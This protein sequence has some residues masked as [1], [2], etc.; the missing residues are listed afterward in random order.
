M[1][2]CASLIALWAGTVSA[3]ELSGR[4][5][6]GREEHEPGTERSLLREAGGPGL[7][8]PAALG[9]LFDS[10]RLRI[11]HEVSFALSTQGAETWSRGRYLSRIDFTLRENLLL[12]MDLGFESV[13]SSAWSSEGARFVLPN[14][15]LSY[16]PT[17]S[18]EIRLQYGYG[19]F[20]SPFWH[21]DPFRR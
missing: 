13:S 8:S 9:G 18:T 21:T 14:F 12:E 11:G 7:R 15:S 6:E 16:R 5:P 20:R 3:R 19:T 4:A 2:L 17:S 10:N 1:A